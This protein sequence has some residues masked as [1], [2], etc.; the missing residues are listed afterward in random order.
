[1]D[2]AILSGDLAVEIFCQRHSGNLP[3]ADGGK[4]AG[5]GEG[6]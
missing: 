6:A 1:M 2:L 4:G 5:D 3:L